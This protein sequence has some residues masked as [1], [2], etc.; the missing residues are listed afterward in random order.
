MEHRDGLHYARPILSRD[1]SEKTYVAGSMCRV[2]SGILRDP[3]TD[4]TIKYVRAAGG[5]IDIDHVVAL[6][7]AWQ[8]GA[9][10]WPAAKRKMFANARVLAACPNQGL[11]K[12]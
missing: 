11:P 5:N 4:A 8:K 7:D 9:Q 2:Q 3:Y 10:Q 1:L 6:M 12:A